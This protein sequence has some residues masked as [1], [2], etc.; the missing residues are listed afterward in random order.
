VVPSAYT[1]PSF[2]R[3]PSYEI[4]SAWRFSPVAPPSSKFL[5]PGWFKT[6]IPAKPPPCVLFVSAPHRL[7]RSPWSTWP[8]PSPEASTRWQ[9]LKA[10]HPPVWLRSSPQ[11][12]LC[13][14]I[15][16]LQSVSI[17]RRFWY[18]RSSPLVA[19]Q[20]NRGA[21]L[22]ESPT[23]TCD[24]A[25]C[26]RWPQCTHQ[27]RDRHSTG[28]S[29]GSQILLRHTVVAR[30]VRLKAFMTRSTTPALPLDLPFAS[31]RG[32]HQTW[33][34]T[35]VM[36][37]RLAFHRQDYSQRSKRYTHHQYIAIF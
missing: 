37:C 28:D 36:R 20:P 14:R 6:L 15:P 8:S 5:L 18:R 32:D 24:A 35:H 29:G 1:T 26:D 16:T 34:L 31:P 12:G 27:L 11:L 19:F 4:L 13:R 25:F 9:F 10:S 22:T 17:L 2:I 7:D 21:R 23:T 3:D 33:W 30:P